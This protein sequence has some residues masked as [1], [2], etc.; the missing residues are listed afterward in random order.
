MRHKIKLALAFAL[1]AVLTL[2]A[3]PTGVTTTADAAGE[4]TAPYTTLRVGL[5]VSTA[6]D[7]SPTQKSFPSANLMNAKGLGSGYE[8][9]Y[10]DENRDFHSLGAFFSETEITML[11]D[12]T[13]VY[14]SG[15]N[16]YS[17]GSEGA[18]VVGCVHLKLNAVFDTYTA[19][20]AV[21]DGYDDAFVRYENGK[22]YVM[23][24]QYVSSAKA[25][26]AKESRRLDATVDSGTSHTV[27]V[28]KSRTNRILFEYD[29]GTA[30]SLAVKPMAPEGVKAQTWFKGCKY[31]GAFAYLRNTGG[32]LTVVNYVD[33]EDYV[34]G[35]VPYEMSA[36]W[37]REALKAQAVAART[38]VMFNITKHRSSGFDVCNTTDCQ[39]YHGTEVEGGA[40]A[41]PDSDAAVDETRSQ[42]L[43]YKGALCD[44]SYCSSNGGA[45]E[46]SENVWT[47]KLDY[48][49]GVL[50]PYEKDIAGSVSNYY[51][52]KTYTPAS[53]GQR[54][55]DMG[56]NSADVVR[57]ELTFT[58]V[59]N[60]YS[61]TFTD[62]N[63]RKNTASKSSAKT[64]LGLRS[65]RF[66]VNGLGPAADAGVVYVNGGIPLDNGLDGVCAVGGGGTAELP[67]G[68]VYAIS[69]AG[70]VDKV[71]TAAV[72]QKGGVGVN[73]AG[74][75]VFSGSG[76]GHNVGM[77]QWGAYSMA[78][79]YGKTYLDILT[80]YYTGT[81]VVTSA[82]K[83]EQ[84]YFPAPDAGTLPTEPDPTDPVPT[85]PETTGPETTGPEATGPEVIGPET[86]DP[87]TTDAPPEESAP[88]VT[89]IPPETTGPEDDG[90]EESP[91]GG[92]TTPWEP[93]LE[94]QAVG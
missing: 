90:A 49:R 52:T 10:F 8:L 16:S 25:A 94:D 79:Y 81:Q 27:T 64:I 1:A 60:V 26:E 7:G 43:V 66:T 39:A 55:R 80:F 59:G 58:D 67:S 20:K 91:A 9:G 83:Q 36:S 84:Q 22:F 37:P 73:S 33:V 4:Y 70:T 12:R 71:D 11:M 13:M 32:N 44:T 88:P 53:L 17:E 78:K 51:W 18:V 24:G 30:S 34:K 41:T 35:V 28:V 89:D 76:W 65:Q 38:F 19:A 6:S 40:K 72:T 77:S 15:S 92:E 48:L 86:T 57:V 23:V 21:A 2:A 42:Y 69:G 63:G 56:R 46:N 14:N 3:V 47:A 29:C 62:V 74:N 5:Y 45:S 31:Y 87:E 93:G 85:D 75:F 61:A 68:D 50:D 54:L 82:R